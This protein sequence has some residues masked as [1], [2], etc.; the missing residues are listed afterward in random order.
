MIITGQKVRRYHD[1][2]LRVLLDIMKCEKT[3]RKAL[4][5][6]VTGDALASAFWSTFVYIL[7]N[8][9]YQEFWWNSWAAQLGL[10]YKK[11]KPVAMAMATNLIYTH[12]DGAA[13][14]NGRLLTSD[15]HSHK[16][17]MIL[18]ARSSAY[19]S[20]QPYRS[21]HPPR[22]HFDCTGKWNKLIVFL[23]TSFTRNFQSQSP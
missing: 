5:P 12:L 16:P 10:L 20:P 19:S 13:L 2:V 6:L 18:T 14:K 11:R 3:V 21:F 17:V 8:M 15:L 7:V 23:E 1:I 9:T 4:Q 22:S